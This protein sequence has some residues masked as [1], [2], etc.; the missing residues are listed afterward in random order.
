MSYFSV[1]LSL[2]LFLCIKVVNL[3]IIRVPATS[4]WR[5]KDEQLTTE[6]VCPPYSSN[7]SFADSPAGYRKDG[8]YDAFDLLSRCAIMISIRSLNH[9]S[10]R[11]SFRSPH[12]LHGFSWTTRASETTLQVRI[13]DASSMAPGVYECVSDRLSKLG[14]INDE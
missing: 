8:W 3:D 9:R 1:V 4:P 12:L 7:W 5:K 2:N 14:L 6:S 10:V 13:D 11:L